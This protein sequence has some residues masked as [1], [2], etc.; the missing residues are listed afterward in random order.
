MG[1]KQIRVY[2]FISDI[3]FLSSSFEILGDMSINV[4]SKSNIGALFS[5]TVI[6]L[7]L[8]LIVLHNEIFF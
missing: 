3:T 7:C 8:L 6:L 5:I 2:S 1:L 4:P